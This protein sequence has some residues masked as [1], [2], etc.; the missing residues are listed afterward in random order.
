MEKAAE[1]VINFKIKTDAK[2]VRYPDRYNDPRGKIMWENIWRIIGNINPQEIQ[3][4]Q[5]EKILL[6]APLEIDFFAPTKPKTPDN[7]TRMRRSQKMMQLENFSE[8][9]TLQ[10]IKKMSNL[11]HMEIVHL[12]RES[13]DIDFDLESEID[14]TYSTYNDAKKQIQQRKKDFGVYR[15]G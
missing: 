7:L 8:K 1:F 6:D 9:A 13:R 12:I 3:Q 14:W 4:R 10:R 11:S 2:T 5:E 15:Y